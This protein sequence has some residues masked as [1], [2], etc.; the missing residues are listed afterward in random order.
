[1]RAYVDRTGPV[2]RERRVDRERYS[3]PAREALEQTLARSRDLHVHRL[4]F[5]QIERLFACC[6]GNR[7]RGPFARAGCSRGFSDPGYDDCPGFQ[8]RE[9][10]GEPTS[11]PQKC[12]LREYV[13]HVAAAV[14]SR[15][16]A[17]PSLGRAFCP[18]PP[19]IQPTGLDHCSRSSQKFPLRGWVL[20]APRGTIRSSRRRPLGFSGRSP[21]TFAAKGHYDRPPVRPRGALRVAESPR[22]GLQGA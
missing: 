4:W 18:G 1:M 10:R 8:R 3:R 19:V 9:R 13:T 5:G 17:D 21:R 22:I 2:T 6:D 14:P 11:G 7:R 15:P 16:G 20:K 12:R